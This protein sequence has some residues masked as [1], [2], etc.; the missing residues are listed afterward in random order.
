MTIPVVP[1]TD[2]PPIMPRRGFQVRSAI[3]SPPGIEN[4]NGNV[5]R[6][7][8]SCR[9]RAECFANH[10]P[11]RRVD[12]RFTRWNRQTGTG[13]RSNTLACV[14]CNAAPRLVGTH[15]H[16]NQRTVGNIRVV[17][18]ILDDPRCRRTVFDRLLRQR[19][20]GC[21]TAWQSNRHRVGKGTGQ[22]CLIRSGRGRHRAGAS[23]PSTPQGTVGFSFHHPILSNL[24]PVR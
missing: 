16:N 9:N 18:G 6:N 17:T 7:A 24:P 3:F 11:W 10:R 21:L 8:M 13:N 5:G 2:K 22:Q 14:K 23:R 12:R 15:G 1:K 19:K 4:R 20:R